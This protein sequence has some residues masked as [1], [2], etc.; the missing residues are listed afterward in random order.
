MGI[1]KQAGII[2]V[3]ICL[4]LFTF[5]FWQ[6]QF[7]YYTPSV[8]AGNIAAIKWCLAGLNLVSIWAFIKIVRAP[9][10]GRPR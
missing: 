10:P 6:I 2:G 4:S 1:R 3:L 9:T 8:P 7:G 5:L